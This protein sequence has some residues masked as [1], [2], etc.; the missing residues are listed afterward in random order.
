MYKKRGK[1]ETLQCNIIYTNYQYMMFLKKEIE[2]CRKCSYSKI[3]SE[4]SYN[5]SQN[6]SSCYLSF[7]IILENINRQELLR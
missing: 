7:N 2:Y 3:S 4:L 6:P 1:S 5:P